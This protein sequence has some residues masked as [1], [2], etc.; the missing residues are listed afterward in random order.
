MLIDF[1][2]FW[3]RIFTRQCWVFTRFNYNKSIF[4]TTEN[5]HAGETFML[6]PTL[7]LG[8][9]CP[10]HFFHSRIATAHGLVAS[11][12][13]MVLVGLVADSRPGLAKTL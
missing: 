5:H 13:A 8:S 2:I 9:Q 6:V 3:R 10:P 1:T 4:I 12:S 11:A 7:F